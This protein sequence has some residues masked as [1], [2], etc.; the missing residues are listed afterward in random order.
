M[1]MDLCAQASEVIGSEFNSFSDLKSLLADKRVLL[2]LDN[3]ETILR[4]S[5]AN[6]SE[7]YEGLPEN[8]KVVVTSRIPVDSAKNIPL[9][10]LDAQGAN[11]L[12]RNYFASKGHQSCDA[13][14]LDKIVQ[15]CRCN[16]LAIRLT[17]DSYLSGKDI[18]EALAKTEK[19]VVAFSFSNLLETLTTKEN[20]VLE[21]IF[22]LGNP[23]RADICDALSSNSDEIAIAI[24][25]LHKT[26][27]ISRKDDGLGETFAL[28]DSIRDLLRGNPRDLEVR[29]QVA[30]WLQRARDSVDSAMKLQASRGTSP[31]DLAYIPSN[32]PAQL[33][34]LAKQAKAAIKREDRQKLVSLESKVRAQ[35]AGEPESS[36]RYRMAGLITLEL[37]DSVTAIDYYNKASQLDPNDPSPLFGLSLI[38]QRTDFPALQATTKILLE[39]GWGDPEKAGPHYAG[40]IFGLHLFSLNCQEKYPEVFELSSNWESQLKV[41]PSFA[42]ARA[43]AYRRLADSEHRKNTLTPGRAKEILGKASN[44]MAKLLKSEEF[45]SWILPELRKLLAEINLY[46]RIEGL[47]LSQLDEREKEEFHSLFTVCKNSIVAKTIIQTPEIDQAI[48]E[49]EGSESVHT[50]EV[51]HHPTRSLGDY[52]VAKVKKGANPEKKFLFLQDDLGRDFYLRKEDFESGDWRKWRTLSHNMEIALQF[53]P[54]PTGNALRVTKAWLTG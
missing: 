16:P 4:D 38:Y 3:L 22:T 7:F 43:S 27:L 15:A 25:R 23:S 18:V 31:V 21:S 34:E 46:R 29:S 44:V 33:I 6:F 30:N 19:D 52:V 51:A 49:M 10:P 5:P 36:F 50:M 48:S 8:W 9:D 32:T 39:N 24:G 54:R 45:A 42:L 2:S 14:L 20:Q 53:D 47:N 35:I 1:K 40:R 11:N 17:I 41:M 28:S 26:S 13:D 12:A 37:G